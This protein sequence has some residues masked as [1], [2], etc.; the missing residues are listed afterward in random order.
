MKNLSD[1][2]RPVLA[3]ACPLPFAVASVAQTYALGQ[4][5]VTDWVTTASFG[6]HAGRTASMKI[7]NYKGTTSAK[8]DGLAT[9]IIEGRSVSATRIQPVQVD[10]VKGGNARGIPPRG[11]PV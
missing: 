6:L 3:A 10:K 1:V 4:P 5:A 7:N 2:Q 11:R 8:G 9:S